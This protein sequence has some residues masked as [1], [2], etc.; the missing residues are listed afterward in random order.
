M[1]A[2]SA[3][4]TAASVSS[5]L[6]DTYRIEGLGLVGFRVVGVKVFRFL[7]NLLEGFYLKSV[8][9][10]ARKR[11]WLRFAGVGM[12]MKNNMVSQLPP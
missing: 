6:A 4:L 3:S 11:S 8:L 1:A 9:Y 5:T 7:N 12:F 10:H 2:F